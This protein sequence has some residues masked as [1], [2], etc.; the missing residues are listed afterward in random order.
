MRNNSTTARE[1][2]RY[3][4]ISTILQKRIVA[5]VKPAEVPTLTEEELLKIQQTPQQVLNALRYGASCP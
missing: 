1:P 3:S 2:L 4:E 5:P